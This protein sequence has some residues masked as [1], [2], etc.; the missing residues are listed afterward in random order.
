M[1]LVLMH[2]IRTFASTLPIGQRK[3]VVIDEA[4][5]LLASEDS[6]AALAEA[7]RTYRKLN[8]AAVFLSQRLEDFEGPHGKAVR[9]NCAVRWLLEQ[10]PEAIGTVR[11]LLDLTPAETAALRSVASR[12]GAYSEAL[13]VTGAG[14][15]IVRLA[16]DPVTYWMVTTDPADL[17]R[18]EAARAEVE[19]DVL[20]ALERLAGCALA[21]DAA[22]SDRGALPVT[23]ESRS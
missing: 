23:L 1:V 16:V 20:A 18:W 13:L 12:K 5:S 2:A 10:A 6:A 11:A 7:A 9:D 3:L 14:S 22:A 8:A 4:W 21:G 17:A 15:G 19:G